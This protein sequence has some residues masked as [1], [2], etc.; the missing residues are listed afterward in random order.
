MDW[1]LCAGTIVKENAVKPTC[2]LQSF[3][4]HCPF[5]LKTA[6]VTDVILNHRLSLQI[7]PFVIHLKNIHMVVSSVYIKYA[8]SIR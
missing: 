8:L 1:L 6:S 3:R 4:N 5:A 7:V 2:K